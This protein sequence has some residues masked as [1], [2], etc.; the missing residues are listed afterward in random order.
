[1]PPSG[2]THEA[3]VWSNRKLLDCRIPKIDLTPALA[4]GGPTIAAAAAAEL[5][6][7]GYWAVP[8]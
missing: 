6:A 5:V 4:A 3:L 1:M 7:A 8:G 2:S